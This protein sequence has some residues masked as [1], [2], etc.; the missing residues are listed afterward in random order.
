MES[1]KMKFLM[2]E[3][4]IVYAEVKTETSTSFVKNIEKDDECKIVE[5]MEISEE[6]TKNM[7]KVKNSKIISEEQV[8]LQ[9][10][11]EPFMDLNF[12]VKPHQFF[13][14]FVEKWLPEANPEDLG[15]MDLKLSI[16]LMKFL[17]LD[18][19]K[20]VEKFE[21][22][23]EKKY[24]QILLLMNINGCLV[25]RTDA[26]VQFSGEEHYVKCFKHK[27]HSHYF[28]EGHMAFLKSVMR[29]PRVKFA[30]NS[31]ITRRNIMPIINNM[32][33]TSGEAGFFSEYMFCLF[34]QDYSQK[35]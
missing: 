18:H 12:G 35:S 29:H 3:P 19:Q 7:E 8:D 20:I 9:E 32:F 21:E 28:R 4:R 27:K 24:P 10:W 33:I 22:I 5:I 16:S 1:K 14:K 17:D 26:M 25:H 6:F 23:V 11:V 15:Y 2:C 13:I 31:S 30:F 34:D